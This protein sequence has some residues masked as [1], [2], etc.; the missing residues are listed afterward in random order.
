VSR[1]DEAAWLE[2]VAG[3][4]A[5]FHDHC[6]GVTYLWAATPAAT[7]AIARLGGDPAR[8][9]FTGP[10]H[11]IRKHLTHE[12][13]QWVEEY[14]GTERLTLSE[15]RV[16]A[17]AERSEVAWMDSAAYTLGQLEELRRLTAERDALV[18]EASRRGATK[19][20]IAAAV[21]LS[22]QQ[23][24]TIVSGADAARIAPVTPIRPEV[25]EVAQDAG[26]WRRLAS[27]EWVEL[28]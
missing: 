16:R 27:G 12:F 19:V 9:A 20:A 25:A 17:V 1:V 6:G 2:Y 22:R 15:W 28:I 13:R 18:I 23:V 7:A 11:V 21:G 5:G 26:E 4:V 8:A 10:W 3:E 24:H 14:E